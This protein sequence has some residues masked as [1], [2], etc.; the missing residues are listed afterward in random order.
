MSTAKIIPMPEMAPFLSSGKASSSLRFLDKV[1][2]AWQVGIRVIRVLE[3]PGGVV[4]KFMCSASVA[5]GLQVQIP[6]QDLAPLW[7]HPT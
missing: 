3:Q 4:V 5:R 6:G 1:E 7:Q 2:R